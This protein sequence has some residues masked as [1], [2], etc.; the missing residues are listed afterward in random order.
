[1]V[2]MTEMDA[3]ATLAESGLPVGNVT[4]T[5]H[6]DPN[7][8]GMVCYQSYSV[9]SYVEKGTPMDLRISTGPS[10]LTYKYSEGITAPTEDPSYQSG[11]QVN[12]T[13]TADDGTQLLNTE[14]TA[15]PVGVNYTGIK[16]A[17]GTIRYT[18]TVQTEPTTITDPETGETES[19]VLPVPERP[20]KIAVFS[21]FI[22]VLAEQCMDAIPLSGR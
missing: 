11:M 17:T 2:G 8:A 3:T 5:P 9:G 20:K 15:F 12:V 4:E 6:E 13:L 10:Q 16:S 22:S 21:P 1:M 7:L 14:T 18:F 19:V